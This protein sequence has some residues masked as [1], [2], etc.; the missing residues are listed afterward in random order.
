MEEEKESERKGV[1]IDTICQFSPTTADAL[2]PS[3]LVITP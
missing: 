1:L 2:T 3:W